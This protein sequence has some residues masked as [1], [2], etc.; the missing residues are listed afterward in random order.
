M[1]EHLERAGRDQPVQPLDRV[2]T[3]I[4]PDVLFDRRAGSGFRLGPDSTG[5][6]DA[7]AVARV[8][9]IAGTQNPDVHVRSS[10]RTLTEIV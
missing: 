10:G 7:P 5:I 9:H 8:R 3:G 2:E 4:I 1:I 6:G